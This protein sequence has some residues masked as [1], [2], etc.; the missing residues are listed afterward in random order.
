M[1]ISGKVAFI[2]G[3]S[4][5]IGRELARI[6]ICMGARVALVAR[7][8]K[9]LEDLAAELSMAGAEAPRAIHGNGPKAALAF[10]ADVTDRSAL[11]RAVSLTLSQLGR[12]D[13][14]VN[15]A[16]IGYFGPMETMAMG[17]FD[18]LLKTNLFGLVNATQ[19]ALPALKSSRG[20]IMNISS[21]LAMRAL[22]F[23]TAYAGTKSMIN[24]ISD[25]MRL[26]LAHY[27]IRVL[28]YCPPATDT[29]FDVKSIKGPGMEKVSFQGMKAEKTGKVAA[30]IAKAIRTEKRLTGGGFFRVMNA[31]MPKLLDRMF[32]G[33]AER[34]FGSA[35]E[36]ER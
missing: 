10:P 27:G 6:L 22:P 33:M 2:T 1:E 8:A 3:A 29:G 25:G 5:G 16:G 14:L 11:D 21:G 34:V 28:C 18:R 36:G 9:T 12:I 26:E 19:A 20:I 24:A 17:D 13:I 23:L 30:D 32:A 31:L 7:S 4:S 35:N 15:N